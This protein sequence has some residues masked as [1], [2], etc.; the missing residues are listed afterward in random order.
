MTF[1][2]RLNSLAT[3][4]LVAVAVVAAPLPTL[5]QRAYDGVWSVV[6]VTE[7]GEC[8]RAYRYPLSIA[9]GVV[10]HAPGVDKS[11]SI[12]GRVTSAGAVNVTIN[13]GKQS[14]KGSGRLRGDSGTGRWTSNNQCSG[15]WTAEKKPDRD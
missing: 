14:A 2:L 12:K 3:L 8:D 13:R 10:A 9:R 4:V 11:F 15:Y 5:A 7:S 1:R 6:I